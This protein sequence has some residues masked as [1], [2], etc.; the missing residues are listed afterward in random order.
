MF[1]HKKKMTRVTKARIINIIELIGIL[2]Y[3]N[4]MDSYFT[5]F[6]GSF[7]FK[8]APRAFLIEIKP[9]GSASINRLSFFLAIY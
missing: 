7:P 6:P 8:L 9:L 3:N 1:K 5:A 4:V 2:M